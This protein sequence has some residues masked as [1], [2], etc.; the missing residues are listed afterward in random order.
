MGKTVPMSNLQANALQPIAG[1]TVHG[2]HCKLAL[3]I[4]MLLVCCQT[5]Y[6]G[7]KVVGRR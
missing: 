4:T 1:K 6:C 3:I 7:T 2:N 5:I